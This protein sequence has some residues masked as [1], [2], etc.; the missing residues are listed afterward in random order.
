MP[1]RRLFDEEQQAEIQVFGVIWKDGHVFAVII[2]QH[3]KAAAAAVSVRRIES[4]TQLFFK[5]RCFF[6]ELPVISRCG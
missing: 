2:V 3:G 5:I 6:P 4:G 1:P